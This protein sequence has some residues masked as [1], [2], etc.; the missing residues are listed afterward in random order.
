MEYSSKLVCI[1]KMHIQTHTPYALQHINA[2]LSRA[3][4]M[5]LREREEEEDI[6]AGACMR[7]EYTKRIVREVGVDSKRTL[8]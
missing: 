2:N 8:A 5:T 4:V 6:H 7:R 1:T 3:A